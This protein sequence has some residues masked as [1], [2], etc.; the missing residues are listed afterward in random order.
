M[1]YSDNLLVLDFIFGYKITFSV[2]KIG[3][4]KRLEFKSQFFMYS[5]LLT[6]LG[7]DF[8]SPDGN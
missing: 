5:N 3:K 1:N 4:K 7:M 8:H 6:P 2:T